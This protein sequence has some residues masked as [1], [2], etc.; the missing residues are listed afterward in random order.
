MSYGMIKDFV[1]FAFLGTSSVIE[2]RMSGKKRN[3]FYYFVEEIVR[4]LR[5]DGLKNVNWIMVNEAA[6]DEEWSKLG[7]SEK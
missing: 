6:G 3:K 5:H 4:D 7:D 2:L 1:L